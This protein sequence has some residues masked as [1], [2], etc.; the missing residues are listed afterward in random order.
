MFG[1]A[2]GEISSELP[3]SK[4]KRH[5]GSSLLPTEVHPGLFPL[6]FMFGIRHGLSERLELSA[7]ATTT[8][9]AEL[10]TRLG[11]LQEQGGAPISAAVGLALGYQAGFGRNAPWLRGSLDLSRRLR[12]HLPLVLNLA[13]SWGHESH[14]LPINVAPS[15]GEDEMVMDAVIHAHVV[16]PELRFSPLIALGSEIQ[17]K[18]AES[19]SYLIGLAP[20]W[21]L[22]YEEAQLMECVYCDRQV[23]LSEF[24]EHWGLTLLVGCL[25]DPSD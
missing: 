10:E 15:W 11:L 14:M 9:R 2:P 17:A 23:Q 7:R 18:G 24:K 13:L 4:S 8:L 1:Y 25:I 16:R 12:Q 19:F 3:P 21:T 5:Q 6:S 20:Y 22:W